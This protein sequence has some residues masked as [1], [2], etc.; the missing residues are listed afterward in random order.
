[1]TNW[2]VSIDPRCLNL[3][4][5][6]LNRSTKLSSKYGEYNSLMNFLT[7]TGMNLLDIIRLSDVNYNKLLNHIFGKT[8]TSEIEQ[9]LNELRNKYSKSSNKSGKY[10]IRYILLDLREETI[11]EV[12]PDSYH[13]NTLI[14]GPYISSKCYPFE[15]KPFISNIAGGKSSKGRLKDIVEIVERESYILML[16]LLQA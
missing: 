8:N 1:M 9:I 5:K 6:I 7:K 2:K 16:I 3:L 13:P 14:D 10:T 12:L 11:E 15:K 4:G